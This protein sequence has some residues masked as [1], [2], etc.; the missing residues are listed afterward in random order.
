MKEGVGKRGLSDVITTVLIIL[1]VLAA[2]III[3]VFVAP[4]LRDAGGQLEPGVLTSTFEIVPGSVYTVGDNV[5]FVVK[6][7]AGEGNVVGLYVVIEENNKNS[8]RVR[9]NGTISQL[10]S[11]RININDTEHGLSELSSISVIPIVVTEDERELTGAIAATYKIKGDEGQQ[12]TNPPP[13]NPPAFVFPVSG[14]VARY[15]FEGTGSVIEDSS[16]NGNDGHLISPATLSSSNCAYG[17]KCLSVNGVSGNVQ[18][19]D[20]PSVNITNDKL[21]MAAWIKAN[22]LDAA[23]RLIIDK[24]NSNSGGGYRLM[25]MDNPVD[26]IRTR[27]FIPVGNNTDTINSLGLNPGTWHDVASAYDGNRQ[28]SY[29]DGVTAK[30]AL[31]SGNINWTNSNLTI[32]STN[33][34]TINW[35]GQIDEVAVWNRALS[36]TEISDLYKNYTST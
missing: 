22:T 13:V 16:T 3:W 14:L 30:S 6:R 26:G 31:M 10:E 25:K 24:S 33:G 19:A 8:K 29:L 15:E 11:K 2:V 34:N 32:G 36:S 12:T 21:T 9:I 27:L 4:A 18:V 20:S 1:L 17:N 5:T 35:N 23:F 28:R 7:S